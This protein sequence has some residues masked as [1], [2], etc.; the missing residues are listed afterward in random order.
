LREA[1]VLAREDGFEGKRLVAYVVAHEGQVPTIGEM[2]RYLQEKLPSYM[3]PTAFVAL[4]HLPLTP[5][6]KV[7]RKALPAPEGDRLNREMVYVAPRT[8]VEEMLAGIW[9]AWLGRVGVENNFFELGALA[10]GDTQVVSRVREVFEIELPVRARSRHPPWQ[11][12]PS[13]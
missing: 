10:A 5:N 8:A 6:G 3:I 9:A 7:D 13:V 2:R 1:I 12:W 11:V 4:D